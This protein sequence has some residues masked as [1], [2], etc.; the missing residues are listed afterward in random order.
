MEGSR[1]LVG[2]NAILY[3]NV[4]ERIIEVSFLIL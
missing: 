1:K 2:F 3:L 4:C